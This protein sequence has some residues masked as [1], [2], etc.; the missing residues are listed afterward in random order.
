MTDLNQQLY[1]VACPKPSSQQA[2]PLTF[3]QQIA[4]LNSTLYLTK[5]GANEQITIL[6]QQDEKQARKQAVAAQIHATNTIKA[7]LSKR[8]N[9][10]NTEQIKAIE[11]LKDKELFE[12]LA[13]KKE[14]A[15]L[16]ENHQP[17]PEL[18]ATRK[19]FYQAALEM[20]AEKN[21]QFNQIKD[22][23]K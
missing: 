13:R 4:D 17:T 10:A 12:E 8:N 11:A 16:A 22:V 18:S 1:L 3:T 20:K 23:K 9:K 7:F 5:T 19:L 21:Q 15:S 14:I 6:S 2:K